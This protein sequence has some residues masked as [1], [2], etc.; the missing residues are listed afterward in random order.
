M[1]ITMFGGFHIYYKASWTTPLK[2][3]LG[4]LPA[5]EDQALAAAS[6]TWV[7]FRRSN[8]AAATLL[9]NV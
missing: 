6:S 4:S 9:I 8:A 3:K 7:Y 5:L 1:E 2:I